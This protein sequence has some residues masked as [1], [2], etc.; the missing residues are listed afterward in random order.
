MKKWRG[1]AFTLIELLVVVAIIAILAAMLLPALGRAK[2]NAKNA[3]CYNN[4][5]QIGIGMHLYASDWDG[6][7]PM[8]TYN[9]YPTVMAWN[10]WDAKMWEYFKIGWPIIER[11]NPNAPDKPTPLS[12]PAGKLFDG[13]G[14]GLGY[15]TFYNNHKIDLVSYAYN[16]WVAE[17]GWGGLGDGSRNLDKVQDPSHL[18]LVVDWS[19][20]DFYDQPTVTCCGPYIWAAAAESPRLAYTRHRGRV[21]ILFADGH[22]GSRR[23]GGT[24]GAGWASW[25]G[26]WDVHWPQRIR[27]C[28]GCPLGA[29]G[30]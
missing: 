29:G 4:L 13:V 25:T 5:R 22:V 2:E 23:S 10:Q 19:I 16:W 30:E 6:S 7:L 14:V 26:G 27:W 28:N 9:P 11:D 24:V 3:G 15:S 21:N 17:D 8:I 1:K 20:A 12:C 18:L